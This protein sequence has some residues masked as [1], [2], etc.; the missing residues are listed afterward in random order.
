VRSEIQYSTIF[1]SD[2]NSLK[3]LEKLKEG[4]KDFGLTFNWLREFS[5]INTNDK[6]VIDAVKKKNYTSNKYQSNNISIK[7][8]YISNYFSNEIAD[9]LQ[10]SSNANI[11]SPVS[12]I[13]LNYTTNSNNL[14]YLNYSEDY[15][16][17]IEQ[18]SF[19]IFL[20]DNAVGKENTLSTISSFIF[21]TMGLYSLINYSNFEN[22]VEQITK[23]YGRKNPYHTDLHAADVEQ[24][25]FIY[26]IHG[27]VKEVNIYL[28]YR[29][30]L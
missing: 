14:N 12:N 9:K 21:I 24:T 10:F 29:F 18:Q 8:A 30:W 4:N 22:F 28:I 19:N 15:I 3:H 7:N 20:L 11:S 2:E 17:D 5:T 26:L 13:K 6:N 23:G 25:C 16:S 27:Q 1:K